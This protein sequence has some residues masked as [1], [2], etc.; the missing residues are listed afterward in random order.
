MAKIV[1][2]HHSGV[3]GGAGI[4]LINTVRELAPL[5][6]ITVFVSDS[7]DDILSQLRVLQ[8]ELNIKVVSY[9]RRIGALTHYSGGDSVCSPRFIYRAL[10]IPKQWFFWRKAIRKE[11]PDIVITNSMIL[12]WM[13]RLPEIRS[14]K[15][16]IFVRET[17]AGPLTKRINRFIFGLLRRFER[18]VFLSEFDRQ[19]W[20][21]PVNRSVVIRNFINEKILDRSITRKEA[22]QKLGLRLTSFHV[23]YVG[24]VSHMKGFDLAVKAVLELNKEIDTDLIVAGIDFSDREEMAGELSPY[25]SEIQNLIVSHPYGNK[26]HLVGRQNDMSNCYACADIL[27]VP[28]RSPHQSRPVFEAGYFSIPVIISDFP[29]IRE[30]VAIGENGYVF[31]SGDESDLTAKIKILANNPDLRKKMGDT[32]RH[33]T[34][35]NHTRE[36]SSIALANLINE[37]L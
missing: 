1:F 22:S 31:K 8:P 23:L 7:P 12:S 24:G 25:E 3:I 9:G 14:R 17:I 32:N 26:I 6:D 2:I 28:M 36:A 20:H 10:L 19:S 16:I 34:E 15:S 4:S 29:H 35:L 13:S 11:N 33:M 27:I 21:F 37:S 5:H 18:V 30:D